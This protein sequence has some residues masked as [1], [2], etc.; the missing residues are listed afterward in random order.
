MVDKRYT[1]N[2]KD[3]VLEDKDPETGRERATI[4]WEC[5]FDLSDAADARSDGTKKIFFPWKAFTPTYRGKVQKDV[6]PL[7][8]ESV[9]RMSLMM[10]R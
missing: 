2:L 9:K 6:E 1:F 5:D 3:D 8:T 7:K 4:S 10:R